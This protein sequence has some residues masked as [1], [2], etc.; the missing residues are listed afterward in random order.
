MS[1]A[2]DSTRTKLVYIFYNASRKSSVAI[3]QLAIVI[4]EL[5]A[6]FVNDSSRFSSYLD[7]FQKIIFHVRSVGEHDIT[8]MMIYTLYTRFPD[9][10]KS[11]LNECIEKYGCWRDIKYFCSY[12]H[13]QAGDDALI[14]Y[15]IQ[16]INRQLYRDKL[17]LDSMSNC[18]KWIPREN[19]AFAWLYE[20][21]AVDWSSLVSP[22]LLKSGKNPDAM[23]RAHNKCLAQYRKT[24]SF[25]NR[26]LDTTEIKLCAKQLDTIVPENINMAT[27]MK[28]NRTLLALDYMNAERLPKPKSNRFIP[29]SMLVKEAIKA[30]PDMVNKPDKVNKPEKVNKPDMVNKQWKHWCK[31][32]HNIPDMLPIIDMGSEINY[33]VIGLACFIA[34]KSTLG[35]R[36]MLFSSSSAGW[37]NLENVLDFSD[38]VRLV[39]NTISSAKI[40]TYGSGLDQIIQSFIEAKM[41]Y[42]DIE[43]LSL[44]ILTNN[45]WG[46]NHSFI[47]SRFFLKNIYII[48]HMVYW[49]SYSDSLV[50]LPCPVDFPRATFLSGVSRATL[51]HF[52]FM[53]LPAVRNFSPY[54]TVSNLVLKHAAK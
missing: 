11:T 3:D 21:L 13:D 27:F 35:R 38:M 12:V 29:F 25:M 10:A 2:F 28:H 47:Q 18:A 46:S 36:I 42:S 31:S 43:K 34:E 1:L 24:L 41:I 9:L 4:S 45:P 48:P 54:E 49:N 50:A 32:Y 40:D 53:G 19:S 6:E 17:D 20:R 8:Y 15:A 51:D 23:A 14:E 7:L 33:D 16:L 22:Q 39:I 26:V 37:I 30:E 44:A 5:L 52:C